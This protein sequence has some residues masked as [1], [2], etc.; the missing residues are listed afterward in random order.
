MVYQVK[1]RNIEHLKQPITAV[2][3]EIT[4]AVLRYVFQAT[5]E[6]WVLCGD[7][8]GEHIVMI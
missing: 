3:E 5:V 2:I 6:R 4:S 8:Q 7:V 1:I